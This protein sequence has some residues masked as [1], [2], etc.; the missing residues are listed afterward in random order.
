MKIKKLMIV[1]CSVTAATLATSVHALTTVQVQDI[2]KSVLSVPVPEM[3]ARAAEIVTSAQKKDRQAV[4]ITAVR[5]VVQKHSAAA[6]LVIAAV[7][8]AAPEVASAVAVAASEVAK[9]QAPA[10]ARAAAV[11]VPARAVEIGA[12]VSK[13]VPSQAASV[14]ATVTPIAT[15]G[16]AA[17]N[18]T[19]VTIDTRPINQQTGGGGN[20]NFPSAPPQEAQ[21]P[22]VIYNAPRQQ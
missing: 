15:R 10:I 1:A 14:N 21:T 8:K 11:S 3:P 6:P 16:S 9:D 19:F 18:P 20:G 5:A 17:N 4:A 22:V 13:A 12:A 7:S 2:K